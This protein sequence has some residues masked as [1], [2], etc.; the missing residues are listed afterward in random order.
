LAKFLVK[1]VIQNTEK[2]MKK[3]NSI[4]NNLFSLKLKQGAHYN[5]AVSLA[6]LL[7]NR[8]KILDFFVYICAQFIGGFFVNR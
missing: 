6:M 4:L 8:M 3:M 5:P 1:I 2:K 7:T